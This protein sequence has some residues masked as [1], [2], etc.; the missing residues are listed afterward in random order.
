MWILKKEEKWICKNWYLM[1]P[2]FWDY[3]IWTIPAPISFWIL[4]WITG[5]FICFCAALRFSSRSDITCLEKRKVL[6]CQRGIQ[7]WLLKHSQFYHNR[8]TISTS[9]KDE[10]LFFFTCLIT[11][12]VRMF[13]ISGSSIPFAYKTQVKKKGYPKFTAWFS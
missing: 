2:L 6:H 11:G 10:S 3:F 5:F 13:R 1:F 4:L 7:I 8:I 9:W 12:S